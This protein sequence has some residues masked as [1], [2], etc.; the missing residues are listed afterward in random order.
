MTEMKITQIVRADGV[1]NELSVAFGA[2][3]KTQTVKCGSIVSFGSQAAVGYG[4]RLAGIEAVT[5]DVAIVSHIEGG[6]RFYF[7]KVAKFDI[8]VDGTLAA[9]A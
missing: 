6:D 8:R 9:V 7:D 1:L 5:V 4:I 2:E 3:I